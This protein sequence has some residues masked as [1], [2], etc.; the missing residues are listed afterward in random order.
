MNTENVSYS[1]KYSF[2]FITYFNWSSILLQLQNW[3]LPK[4]T[5][6]SL[7]IKVVL[8]WQSKAPYKY[9][10]FSYLNSILMG[11]K[12]RG[13]CD[14]RSGI[15]IH[16]TLYPLASFQA[17]KEQDKWHWLFCMA[18]NWRKMITCFW[19]I[20]I[21]RQSIILIWHEMVLLCSQSLLF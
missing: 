12:V 20:P 4:S 7:I 17:N 18:A 14:K 19:K 16:E 8:M 21:S 9:P 6:K 1:N 15:P 11:E 13:Y 2:L 3:F 5:N 10:V